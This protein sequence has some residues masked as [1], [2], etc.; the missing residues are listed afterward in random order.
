MNI[1]GIQNGYVIDH[2][3]AGRAMTIYRYLGLDRLDCSVAIIKNAKSR[4]MGRKDMIK[5]DEL[6]PIDLEIL[7]YIDPSVTVNIIRDGERVD[8]KML[9]LPERVVNIIR[10]KNPRCITQIEQE[11]EHVFVL[12]DREKGVYRCHY[13][14]VPHKSEDKYEL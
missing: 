2:I 10:C 4:R 1:D 6:I 7:G 13:C 5:I 14:E 8:K 9:A 11:I 3:R 12:S